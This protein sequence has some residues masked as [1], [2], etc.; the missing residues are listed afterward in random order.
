M[1]ADLLSELKKLQ[2]ERGA[3]APFADQFE[4]LRWADQVQ[5]RL[6]FDQKLASAFRSTVV[7]VDSQRALRLPMDSA[8]NES[9]GVLNQAV[10]ALQHNLSTIEI[11]DQKATRAALQTPTA[12]TLQWIWQNATWSVYVWFGGLVATAFG[13]GA[14]VN[15]LRTTIQSTNLTATP[16]TTTAPTSASAVLANKTNSSTVAPKQ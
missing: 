11:Q 9:I 1:S 13:A 5:P 6:S 10:I 7:L 15:E 2:Y 14:L 12:L 4:F 8:M 3:K 16:Q